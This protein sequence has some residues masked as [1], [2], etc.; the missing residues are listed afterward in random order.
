MIPDMAMTFKQFRQARKDLGLTIVKFADMLG[1][2]DTHIRRMMMTP[3]M[4]NHRPVR[5][6]VERLLRAYLDGYRPPDWPKAKARPEEIEKE[7][8]RD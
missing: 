7:E 1:V 2:S 3:G 4:E 6:T 5:P 8:P